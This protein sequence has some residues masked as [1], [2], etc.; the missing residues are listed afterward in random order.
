MGRL[1]SRVLPYLEAAALPVFAISFILGPDFPLSRIRETVQRGRTR[2]DRPH[3][4][5]RA[6]RTTT[7]PGGVAT[8]AAARRRRLEKVRR[9]G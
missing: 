9:R 2:E 4:G 8:H 6:R 1:L 5:E 7:R 3:K